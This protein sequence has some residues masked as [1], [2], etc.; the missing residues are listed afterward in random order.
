MTYLFWLLPIAGAYAFT[1]WM[2]DVLDWRIHFLT[3][4]L[5]DYAKEK[6][7]CEQTT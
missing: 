5:L 7:Q 4:R 2:E 1:A 3:D 6:G